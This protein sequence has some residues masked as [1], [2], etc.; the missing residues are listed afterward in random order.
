MRTNEQYAAEAERVFDQLFSD[1]SPVR[2]LSEARRENSAEPY[3][4]E[5]TR[6]MFDA[7]LD[8][9]VTRFGAILEVFGR[10]RS[11]RA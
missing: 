1:N 7:G 11:K 4:E 10:P 9:A 3:R 8:S 5:E 6:R 2:H